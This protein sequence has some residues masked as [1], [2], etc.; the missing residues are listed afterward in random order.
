[1]GGEPATYAF[2]IVPE[3]ST[4]ALLGLGAG[5]LSLISWRRRAKQG[6]Y[7]SRSTTPVADEVIQ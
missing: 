6:R 7:H 1:V 2:N 4:Y 3:P 5:V